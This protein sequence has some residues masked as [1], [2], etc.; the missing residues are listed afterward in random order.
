[1]IE[2]HI[3]QTAKGYHPD[4]EWQHLDNQNK[5]FANKKEAMDWLKEEYGTCKRV[6]MYVDLDGKSLHS[7]FVFGFRNCDISHLP[8]AKWIQQDWVAFVDCKPLILTQ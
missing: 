8:V 1:M 6:K 4:D 2:L 5:S 7:G 3:N